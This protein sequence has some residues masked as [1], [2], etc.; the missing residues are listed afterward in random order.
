M[1]IFVESESEYVLLI[2]GAMLTCFTVFSPHFYVLLHL[3]HLI[4]RCHTTETIMFLS[5]ELCT[6]SPV[7]QEEHILYI[8][9]RHFLEVAKFDTDT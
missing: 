7:S 4:Q 3:V 8:S 2:K 6:S 5:A 9:I 1:R